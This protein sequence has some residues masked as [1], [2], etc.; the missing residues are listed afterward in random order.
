MGI[1]PMRVYKLIS[2]G[3]AT[4][5]ALYCLSVRG[6]QP[7]KYGD[8]DELSRGIITVRGTLRQAD[9]IITNRPPHDVE[10]RANGDRAS[11][12]SRLTDDELQQLSGLLYD[13]GE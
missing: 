1:K 6:G 2:G 13:V 3:E 11:R 5:T 9:Y 12:C 10:W 7:Y 4:D 8:V